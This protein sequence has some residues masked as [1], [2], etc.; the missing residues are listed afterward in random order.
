MKMNKWKI[1][2]GIVLISIS[3]MALMSG[4]DEDRRCK[5]WNCKSWDGG[6][7]IE[8]IEVDSP[9]QQLYQYC[10]CIENFDRTW[11]VD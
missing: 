2:M 4:C 7:N 10:E 5:T 1:G 6:G 9:N 8:Y 3:I 11:V